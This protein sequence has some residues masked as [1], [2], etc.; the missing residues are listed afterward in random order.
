MNT[1]FEIWLPVK[2]YEGKYEVSNI[3]RVRTLKH[4]ISLGSRQNKTIMPRIKKLATNNKGYHSALL[5]KNIKI[6]VHR[7]VATAFID[8][9]ENKPQVNHKNGIRND[10]RV[11]NLEWCT[12][13]ENE[14]HSYKFLGH[15]KARK[16]ICLNNGKTYASS[17]EASR[18]LC[19]HTGNIW[20]VLNG[21]RQHTGGLTFK[22][23]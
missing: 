15:K 20:K 2:G 23:A 6:Y 5:S 8:N 22:Y 13:S 1:E 10:N 21:E 9:S 4:V 18:E 12:Q 19:V 17:R 11:E 3:G 7:L 14:V 16:I